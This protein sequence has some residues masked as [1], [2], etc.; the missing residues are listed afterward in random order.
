MKSPYEPSKKWRQQG[1]PTP[2]AAQYVQ[3]INNPEL[4][5]TAWKAIY[6]TLVNHLLELFDTCNNKDKKRSPT[7]SFPVLPQNLDLKEVN[8][9]LELLAEMIDAQLSIDNEAKD[10]PLA[11]NFPVMV[12]NADVERVKK[13]LELVTASTKAQLR[14]SNVMPH[15]MMLIRE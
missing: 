1:H 8:K 10:M 12:H 6:G 5:S 15:V 4:T 13:D 2:L 11:Q 9:D 7:Y 14:I 3:E